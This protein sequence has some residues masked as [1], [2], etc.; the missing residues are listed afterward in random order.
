M[1]GGRHNAQGGKPPR[2]P[3]KEDLLSTIQSQIKTF[4]KEM[5]N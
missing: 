3:K 4:P 5:A 1:G 2:R